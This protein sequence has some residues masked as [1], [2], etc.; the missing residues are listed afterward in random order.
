MDHYLFLLKKFLG[1]LL[2]P[3]PVILLLLLWALLLLLR[4]KTRWF[5]I[6]VVFIVTTLLFVGSY[7]PLSHRFIS[8]FESQ[9]P[10]YQQPEIPVDYIAVLGSWHQ[11][12]DDQPVTSE[13]SPTA[14][15]RLTEGI[16][17]YRMNPGSKLIFT[18]FRGIIEDSVSYPEK[19]RQLAVALGIPEKD[20]I[21]LNGPRDTMEE[22]QVIADNFSANSLVLVTTA[23]HMPRALILFHQAGLDPIPA[24]TEHLSK[25]FKSWWLFPS[26]ETLAHSEY[27]AH[28]RLGLLWVKLTKQV[29]S[30]SNQD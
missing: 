8:E 3:V 15:V 25:P 9:I 18:G 4:P 19:L 24:P 23:L 7:S 11:S 2:M 12:V 28:E 13:L 17:I 29:S 20:I 16:R 27:W 26:A 5:G 14:I 21:V 1:N 6:I 30:Y 10:T 22:A